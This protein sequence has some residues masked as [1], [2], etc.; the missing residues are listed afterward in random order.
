LCFGRWFSPQDEV[1]SMNC[2]QSS[3][4]IIFSL[5]ALY[6]AEQQHF[7]EAFMHLF[8]HTLQFLAGKSE[9]GMNR[10]FDFLHPIF[11]FHFNI[12]KNHPFQFL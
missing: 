5:F 1:F 10:G 6:S 2:L 11:Y 7:S 8:Q 9:F 4:V 3:F 12:S